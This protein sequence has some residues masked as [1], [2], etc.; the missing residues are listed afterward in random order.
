MDRPESIN[1]WLKR[2]AITGNILAACLGVV[3]A[4]SAH[5]QAPSSTTKSYVPASVRASPGLQCR[6]HPAD[7]ASS[8]GVTVFTDAD[9]YARFYAVKASSGDP[10][11][12]FTLDCTNK[13]GAASAY[14][15]DLSAD[16]TFAAHPIDL[17]KEPGVDR[18]ALKG[19]QL[20]LSQQQLVDAG[21]GLRPDPAKSPA[22][23]ARWLA[24]ASLPGRLLVN[25]K[26]LTHKH[27]V[28]SSTDGLWVGSVLNGAQ[29][30]SLIEATFN[31][32]TAVPGG[33]DTDDTVISVWVGI[34]GAFTG[35]GLMQDG[36]D[37]S[38]TP[39][40]ASYASFQEYCCGDASQTGGGRFTLNAKD[41][42]Y[43]E[44]WYC[45]ANGNLNLNGGYGCAFVQ[46]MTSGAIMSCASATGSPCGSVKANVLC[47]VNPKAANCFTL[48]TSADFVIEN[49]SPQAPI[50]SKTFTDFNDKVTMAGSA[51]STQTDSLSQTISNDPNVTVLTDWT[52]LSTHIVVNLGTTDQTYFNI[53]PGQASYAFYCQ[54]P[55]QTSP[56]PKPET[57]FKWSSKGAGIAPPGAGECAWADRGPRGTEVKTG[58][59]NV[60]SGYLNDEANLAAGKYMKLG[61]Y[62]DAALNHDMV[63]R[64]APAPAAPPFPATVSP[65]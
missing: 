37:V 30:Y 43:A 25:D 50:P 8:T 6:L 24:A 17:S 33:D 64:E 44:A 31:V 59:S 52:N 5:A 2:L 65:P 23:Y 3:A 56:A 4:T 1:N 38:T 40:I 27:G 55:L 60:I 58:D 32:P 14:T 53:E 46:D 21:Y 36:V 19:D 42:V 63:V 29:D 49:D 7:A 18:P 48:G 15:V 51:F 35:P 16:D 10:K 45:D 39:S 9:G 20:G 13:T 11:A 12:R 61:V 22:A 28:S 26:P 54:G 57:P 62:N 41:E 47:S 34:G